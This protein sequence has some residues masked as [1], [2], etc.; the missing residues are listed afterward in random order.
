MFDQFSPAWA[1]VIQGTIMLFI[2]AKKD[3]TAFIKIISYGAY[4]VS[5]LIATIVGFGIYSF[6]NT[7]FELKEIPNPDF[8][9][10]VREIE[11]FGYGFPSLAG[12]LCVGYFL[13]PAA[14]PILK[15]N[16][17]QKNNN[18]DLLVSYFVVFMF[19]SLVGV[20]GYFG[21]KGTYFKDYYIALQ[22][23]G[24]PLQINSNCLNMFNATDPIGFILRCLFFLMLSS[25]FPLV[26]HILK[27]MLILLIWRKEVDEIPVR[28]FRVVGVCTLFVPFLFAVFY[29][30]V[31]AILSWTGSIAGL[32]IIYI[33]PVMLHLKIVRTRLQNPLLA[34]A[35]EY[36]EFKPGVTIDKQHE[37]Y[38]RKH[39]NISKADI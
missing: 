8:S 30:Q 23:A 7:D 27:S 10:N 11:M 24:S 21:F 25:T 20:F 17:N 33:L 36:N 35:L 32:I 12:V 6:T 39:S 15:N 28:T 14:I 37:A 16:A 22:K 18:R 26:N 3:L 13:H 1:A 9:S 2:T 38:M 34:K 4:F 29:P 5:L 19:F 31:G